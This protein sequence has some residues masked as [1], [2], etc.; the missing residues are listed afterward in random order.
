MID[1]EMYALLSAYAAG[2]LTPAEQKRLFEKSLSNQTLFDALADEETMRA[3]LASPLV[4]AAALKA[5]N[6][7]TQ[8]PAPTKW[9]WVALAASLA[10]GALTIGFWPGNKPEPPQ[11]AQAIKS[12]LPTPPE[13]QAPAAKPTISTAPRQNPTQNLSKELEKAEAPP[14]EPIKIRESV[15]VAETALS[16]PNDSARARSAPAPSALSANAFRE[17]AAPPIATITNNTLNLR[18]N[19]TGFLYAF[20]IDGETIRPLNTNSSTTIPL[21][22]HSPQAEVWFL[23]TPTE[24]PVLARALTGVLPLPTRNWTKLKT[25]P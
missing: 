23:T 7:K 4:K 6:Q 5:L 11:I 10:A 15:T 21:G 1:D 25:N 16:I 22:A 3:V 13:I 24:D 14:S 18:T 9:L 17:S 12:E 8:D 20:L 2:T 19:A